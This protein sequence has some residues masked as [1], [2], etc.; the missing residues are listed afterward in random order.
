MPEDSTR[1][2]GSVP[3]ADRPSADRLA[4]A[5]FCAVLALCWALPVSMERSPSYD[6][7]VNAV[8]PALR[9]A[10]GIR[11]GDLWASWDALLDCGRYP[12]V[13]PEVLADVQIITGPSELAARRTV[14]V[15]WAAACFVLF[16]L[17]REVSDELGRRRGPRAG[18]R[19]AP[20]L[21]L[22]FAV[23]SPLALAYSGTLYLEIPFVFAGALAVWTWTRRDGSARRELVA[24]LCVTAA[25]FTKFNYGLLLGLALALDLALEGIAARDPEA[26]GAGAFARRVG[27][28]AVAPLVTFLWWF[29]LVRGAA[30]RA[31]FAAFIAGNT[32]PSMA[33]GWDWRA[34]NAGAFFALSPV[35]L[36][37]LLVGVLRALP[38]VRARAAR[39]LWIA[40][41]VILT[42]LSLHP[43]HME[44]FYL[45]AGLPL[46][47]LAGLGWAE[48]APRGARARIVLGALVVA[49]V[50]LTAAPTGVWLARAAGFGDSQYVRDNLAERRSLSGGRRV[51][52]GLKRD[53]A[54]ALL[55]L[56]AAA[57]T[58][59]ERIGWLGISAGLSRGTL[60]A[61]LLERTGSTERLLRDAREVMFVETAQVDPGH[62]EAEL[63]K[64]AGRFD[65]VLHTDPVDLRRRPG[66]AFMQRYVDLLHA[67][68]DWGCELLGGVVIAGP[69]E[70][71]HPVLLHACRRSP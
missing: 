65:V 1:P 35:A 15:L 51:P 13:F 10:S 54:D 45:V 20:W 17:V 58:P 24:G 25:F 30:H 71:D 7:S 46:W 8:L 5:V 37:I 12:F 28:L 19:L 38:L 62:G 29:V 39:S 53:E 57:S 44:R 22:A 4:A 26:G 59:D 27:W 47:P 14:R 36:L 41:V 42:A 32:D 61:G 23:T 2:P 66:R 40:T 64:W 9:M 49:L 6:E 33:V 56:I 67:R 3:S 11:G 69:G 48:L 52:G 21:A 16:L 63:M 31:A 70:G 18:D 55:D 68:A 43:F 34:V 50:A 60:L